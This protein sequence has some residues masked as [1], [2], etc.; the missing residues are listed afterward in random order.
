V[1]NLLE[2]E[3]NKLLNNTVGTLGLNTLEGE[4]GDI[5]LFMTL[6]MVSV[7]FLKHAGEVSRA[8]TI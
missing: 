1:S 2:R 7:K 6:I 3:T 4:H 5:T 8:N